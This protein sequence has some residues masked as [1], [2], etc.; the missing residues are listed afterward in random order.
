[1]NKYRATK[2]EIDNISFDSVAESNL[3]VAIK[4]LGF[5]NIVCQEKILIFPGDKVIKPVYWKVDFYLPEINIYLEYKGSV[6]REFKFK[7]LLLYQNNSAIFDN[8]LFVTDKHQDN[9]LLKKPSYS[10]QEIK[11]LSQLLI[12]TNRRIN[13]T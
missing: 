4:S 3:Y 12:Q 6:T 8:L 11:E 1:M 5:K 9:F 10:I 13:N 2:R 7:M